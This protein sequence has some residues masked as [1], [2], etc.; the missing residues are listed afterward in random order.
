M[1]V[2]PRRGFRLGSTATRDAVSVNGPWGLGCSSSDG[3]FEALPGAKSGT[4]SVPVS[5]N[6]DCLLLESGLFVVPLAPRDE[7]CGLRCGIA[8][9]TPSG[10]VV[11]S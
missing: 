10:K 6:L 9:G 7:R 2:A 4:T 1:L 3:L 11:A 5:T 8:G